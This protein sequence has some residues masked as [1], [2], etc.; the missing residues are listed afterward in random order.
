MSAA[1]MMGHDVRISD[2]G[3]WAAG[4]I[5]IAISRDNKACDVNPQASPRRQGSAP[6]P[7]FDDVIQAVDGSDLQA[8]H[9]EAIKSLLQRV[10]AEIGRG[11]RSDV[12]A[13]KRNLEEIIAIFPDLR[14]RLRSLIAASPGVSTPVRIVANQLLS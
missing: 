2:S 11:D 5:T 6:A 7:D 14:S 12:H 4:D 9:K 1:N 10:T 8:E 13:V 3:L